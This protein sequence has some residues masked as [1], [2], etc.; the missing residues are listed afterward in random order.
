MWAELGRG[1]E[2]TT[3]PPIII[4]AF[5]MSSRHTYAVLFIASILVLQY[6][7]AQSDETYEFHRD[8]RAPKF[9]RF[10]RGGGAKFIRFGR[11]GTN[12]WLHEITCV[13]VT[14]L[15]TCCSSELFQENDMTDYEGGLGMLR[16]DK[17]AAKFIRFG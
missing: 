16:E 10:G 15:A 1:A 6:V 12:T 5:E 13:N 4:A 14:Y 8:A 2:V 17:R 3:G 11:S 9:I 7:T